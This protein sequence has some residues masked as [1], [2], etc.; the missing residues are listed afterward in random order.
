M[1]LVSS[2]RK[3]YWRLIG[4]DINKFSIEKE[5]T[6][7]MTSDQIE[8][9]QLSKLRNVLIN[10]YDN[11]PHYRKS[12]DEIGFDPRDLK[13]LDEFYQISYFTTKEDIQKDTQS[14]ISRKAKQNDLSWHRTGGSTGEPLYFAT[15]KATDS[16]SQT[17]IMRAL[18]WFGTEFGAKHVIFWGSPGYVV[19]NKKDLVKKFINITRDRLM[20][21]MFIS[22]YDLSSKNMQKY[23]ED[24]VKFDPDYVRG[25]ASSL[26][27]F[28]KFMNSNDLRFDNIKV[29]HSACE[30]LF[31][32]QKVEIE[33]A[34]GCHVANTY[35]LSEVCDI[36]Y[37]APCGN[38]H[39]SDEDVLLELVSS[40]LG[41]E[42][43]VTQL[44]NLNSPLIRYRT[45]DLA[46]SIGFI[47]NVQ[48]TRVLVGLKGRAHDT[49][50]CDGGKVIHGQAFTHIMVFIEGIVKYQIIQVGYFEFEIKLVVFELAEIEII[51]KE[52]KEG[53]CR[54][55]SE[56]VDLTFL[57]VNE[58]PLTPSGKHRWIISKL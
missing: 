27:I 38:L 21:R 46:E 4:R 47:G 9:L 43:V 1:S 36:A 12:F 44:N 14:F 23:Y 19:R 29:V 16:G 18:K 20:N 30:Q 34:F 50:K 31:D 40:K 49:I 8:E 35:G 15:D 33:K 52:I 22:N 3:V 41:N 25:M 51:E 58:I 17:S 32:W 28:A 57:Y 6:Y 39:I 56:N 53:F 45:A 13:S 2:V 37:E 5:Q 54:L 7:S 11:V 10:A 26:Y 42:I 24:I 55:V 48:K